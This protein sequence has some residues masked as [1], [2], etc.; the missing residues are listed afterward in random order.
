MRIQ[1]WVIMGNDYPD[2]VFSNEAAARV[3]CEQ[4]TKEN[5]KDMVRGDSRK[6]YWRAYD[7]VLDEH[8]PT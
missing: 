8:I 2:A 7:F 5:D 3:Y 6:I 4:K 1:V